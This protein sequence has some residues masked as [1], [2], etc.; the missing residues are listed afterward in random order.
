MTR[1][2]LDELVTNNP[3]ATA[4][5]RVVS[6]QC[7]GSRN[8]TNPNCSRVCCQ[9]AVKHAREL[10]KLNPEMEIMVLCRDI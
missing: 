7:V 5:D 2:Q 1:L 9:T 6:I 10:K 8:E 4:F 3:G